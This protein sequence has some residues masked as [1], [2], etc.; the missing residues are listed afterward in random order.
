[1]LPANVG[2][3]P[4]TFHW[5]WGNAGEWAA[6]IGTSAAVLL[7]AKTIREDRLTRRE[8]EALR[9]VPTVGIVGGPPG[10]DHM[11][12]NLMLVSVFNGGYRTITDIQVELYS[13]DSELLDTWHWA[14]VPPGATTSET[15]APGQDEWVRQA[16]G[17]I[18]DSRAEVTFV[19]ADGKRWL[20]DSE[21][22]IRVLR[23]RRE[24]PQT[25]VT[26][27]SP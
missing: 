12:T 8:Q 5:Q 18:F 14:E 24:R 22:R 2:S 3:I 1:M 19:D 23:G 16:S 9:V 6:A 27:I 11:P 7:S 15:R 20:R 4:V 13:R 25:H 17:K 10:T 26:G 21:G